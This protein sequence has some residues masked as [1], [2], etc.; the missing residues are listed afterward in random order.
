[1]VT[2]YNGLFTVT[3]AQW[4][5]SLPV[6]KTSCAKMKVFCV[7]AKNDQIAL[8]TIH[9]G[10]ILIDCKTMKLKYFNENNGLHNNTVLSVAFD[11]FGNLWAGLEYGIDY[12]CLTLLLRIYIH[13]PTLMEADIRQQ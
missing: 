5:H 13:T 9:K 3:D 6:P 8:G 4:N 7:A 10:L 12:V 1:M 2:A 11:T